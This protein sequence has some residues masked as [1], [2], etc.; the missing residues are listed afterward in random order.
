M[1]LAQRLHDI[2][3]EIWEERK[4]IPR[5]LPLWVRLN[6]MAGE[7]HRL[8]AETAQEIGFSSLVTA[9]SIE[10]VLRFGRPES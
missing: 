10:N 3:D 1:D 2:A 4:W 5:D 6:E 8:A 9:R 7:L